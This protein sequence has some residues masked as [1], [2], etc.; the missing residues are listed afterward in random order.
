MLK[1]IDKVL[2]K[3]LEAS[4]NEYDFE[5]TRNNIKLTFEHLKLEKEEL[6]DR[7]HQ[8]SWLIT[9]L[10]VLVGYSPVI[11]KFA[12]GNSSTKGDIIVH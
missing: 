5:D 9:V 2:D 10:G 8:T 11:V 7:D 12:I 6:V 1:K 4:D 3:Y